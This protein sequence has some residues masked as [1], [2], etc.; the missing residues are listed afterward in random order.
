[1]KSGDY[2]GA[3]FHAQ[4]MMKEKVRHGYE[5]AVLKLTLAQTHASLGHDHEALAYAEEATQ[6]TSMKIA[7]FSLHQA[8]PP[9]SPGNY[10]LPKDLV[11]DL[12]DLRMRLAARNGMPRKA[13]MAYYELAGLETMALDDPRIAQAAE[14]TAR[15]E[16]DEPLA[17]N[18][19]L[20][21]RGWGHALSRHR[22]TLEHMSGSIDSITLKCGDTSRSLPYVPGEEWAVPDV[23]TGLHAGLHRRAR[24]EIPARRTRRLTTI[25]APLT[26]RAIVTAIFLKY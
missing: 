9:N 11:V 2:A 3:D 10:M 5:F 1:M 14:F 12:L 20:L 4:W 25:P 23:F 16:S 18:I 8:I 24:N 26:Q 21:K 6:R 15:L 13:L 7:E 22:F 19:V 17:A